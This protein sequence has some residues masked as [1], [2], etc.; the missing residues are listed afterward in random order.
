MFFQGEPYRFEEFVVD[1]R[2]ATTGADLLELLKKAVGRYGYDRISLWVIDDPDLP[3]S[4]HGRGTLHNFPEDLRN[5]YQ[6]NDCVKYDPILIA[7]RSRPQTVDWEAFEKRTNYRPVQTELY[8]VA[9]SGGL[10]NGISTPIWGHRGL[11]A[12]LAMASSERTDATLADLD[13]IAAM[14]AQFYT[15]FKRLYGHSVQEQKDMVYLSAKETEVLAWVAAGKTDEDIATI[16]SISRN[17]VDSHM[18]HIF[19]KLG[20]HSRVTAVVMGLSRGH[21][22][23]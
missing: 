6:E 16:L 12:T 13:L 15:V 18:R 1:T 7:Q 21:I 4:A 22:S 11:S 17:T 5:Y 19:Q 8:N 23:L 10:H 9:R 14:S 2:R 20:V 3:M